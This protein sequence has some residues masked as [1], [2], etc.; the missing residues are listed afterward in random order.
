MFLKWKIFDTVKSIYF[1]F[2][3]N[4]W[5][6]NIEYQKNYWNHFVHYLDVIGQSLVPYQAL[7]SCKKFART[8]VIWKKFGSLSELYKFV[9]TL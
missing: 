7:R 5:N 1:C 3:Q 2:C 8:W 6:K 4:E 9:R